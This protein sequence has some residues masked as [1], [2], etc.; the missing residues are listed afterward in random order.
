MKI[1]DP[2]RVRIDPLKSPILSWNK[3]IFKSRIDMAIFEDDELWKSVQSSRVLNNN[4]TRGC[5]A[6]L[7]W[8]VYVYINNEVMKCHT[9]GGWI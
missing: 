4:Y 7:L 8:Y 9:V 6:E 3:L 1:L 2:L 5:M